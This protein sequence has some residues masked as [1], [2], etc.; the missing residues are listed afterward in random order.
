MKNQPIIILLAGFF[1]GVNLLSQSVD[2]RIRKEIFSSSSITAKLDNQALDQSSSPLM[3]FSGDEK[4]SP[5]EG[6]SDPRAAANRDGATRGASENTAVPR[7]AARGTTVG[8]SEK[9]DT[10]QYLED[11]IC[12]NIYT[13]CLARV[14][15]MTLGKIPALAGSSVEENIRIEW[16]AAKANATSD[17]SALTRELDNARHDTKRMSASEIASMNDLRL[18]AEKLAEARLETANATLRAISVKQSSFSPAAEEALVAAQEKEQLAAVAYKEAENDAVTTAFSIAQGSWSSF[19]EAT[20][21]YNR[22]KDLK[23]AEAVS[24]STLQVSKTAQELENLIKSASPN[25]AK[26]LS[27]A[28]TAVEKAKNTTTIPGWEMTVADT[29]KKANEIARVA[30]NDPNASWKEVAAW[31]TEKTEGVAGFAKTVRAATDYVLLATQDREEKRKAAEAAAAL[32]T[33]KKIVSSSK[34]PNVTVVIQERSNLTQEKAA[35]EK[36]EADLK[37]KKQALA[38]KARELA[39]KSAELTQQRK[40][41][42]A[43]LEAALKEA[44]SA[45]AAKVRELEER[46]AALTLQEAAL[47][48]E[49]AVLDKQATEL[50]TTA[51]DLDKTKKEL[52]YRAVALELETQELSAAREKAAEEAAAQ[53]VA[54]A[55]EKQQLSEKENALKA[56]QEE[57]DE[58]EQRLDREKFE[59]SQEKKALEKRLKSGKTLSV[60]EQKKWDKQRETL[61]IREEELNVTEATWHQ[62]ISKHEIQCIALDQTKAALTERGTALSALEK[63]LSD[64]HTSLAQEKINLAK[65]LEEKTTTHAEIEARLVAREEE[66]AQWHAQKQELLA[67]QLHTL[68]EREEAIVQQQAALQAQ[69]IDL[70]NKEQ[71]R[72]KAEQALNQDK[73]DFEAEKQS[74]KETQAKMQADMKAVLA[75]REHALEEEKR[76][77]VQKLAAI[78]S[79]EEPIAAQQE[80]LLKQ[81]AA[82]KIKEAA[83]TEEEA[84]LI[85]EREIQEKVRAEAEASL[86]IQQKALAQKKEEAMTMA[87]TTESAFTSAETAQTEVAWIQ[88]R[89]LA[90]AVEDR[91]NEVMEAQQ[92]FFTALRMFN[93]AAT[94]D[95]GIINLTSEIEQTKS[96]KEFWALKVTLADAEAAVISTKATSPSDLV[97]HGK[98]AF[99]KVRS[100]WAFFSRAIKI[101][102]DNP[103]EDNLSVAVAAAHLAKNAA[104]QSMSSYYTEVGPCHA[105]HGVGNAAA[106]A[107][108]Y[109]IRAANTAASTIADVISSVS[110]TSYYAAMTTGTIWEEVGR[111]ATSA[112]QEAADFAKAVESF[113]SG[114]QNSTQAEKAALALREQVLAQAQEVLEAQITAAMLT[115]K[116]ASIDETFREAEV[117]GLKR[118]AAWSQAVYANA[119]CG[120]WGTPDASILAA[121][122]AAEKALAAAEETAIT[123]YKNYALAEALEMAKTQNP[124]AEAAWALRITEAEKAIIATEEAQQAAARNATARFQSNQSLLDIMGVVAPFTRAAARAV[125]I[126]KA[127]KAA[128]EAAWPK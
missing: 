65:L 119:S 41:V 49:R 125:G 14:A 61:A 117:I 11:A 66:I 16:E 60:E 36:R 123:H 76:V 20:Q 102:N 72:M 67:Q 37:V 30:L 38:L 108:N 9:D 45:S 88:A 128:F 95:E 82:L 55:Q 100:V 2:H 94:F 98:V 83:R 51:A 34:A 22:H 1:C 120:I 17:V 118:D 42:Q 91:W 103:S 80:A 112:A 6:T 63:M 4:K 99:T 44:S 81:E 75:S 56:A 27:H 35:L 39:A 110:H 122:S 93:A 115:R 64:E 59:L 62:K 121:H 68:Q 29:V 12:D 74:H 50:Q 25:I 33:S 111:W 124:R 7:Q 96:Q 47:T 116:E 77:L 73:I 97:A 8:F 71:L 87:M 126:A 31:I 3:M 69:E 84:R 101:F 104:H 107:A 40:A 13:A 90:H 113:R 53:K 26:A 127:D 85:Q 105:N 89:D 58:Q 114:R 57:I 79:Q 106:S 21:Q 15:A 10:N 48:Q 24:T 70:K 23:H 43:A 78:Q 86:T 46:L 109:A 54:L 18:L 19:T 28:R 32:R 92:N 52:D 5:S